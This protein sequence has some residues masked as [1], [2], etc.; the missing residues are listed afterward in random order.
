M[1]TPLIMLSI[2][3]MLGINATQGLVRKAA[4]VTNFVAYSLIFL[5]AYLLTTAIFG[6]GWWNFVVP[7]YFA[8]ISVVG[9]FI[10]PFFLKSH[11]NSQ[12]YRTSE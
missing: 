9:L 10:I 12:S 6:I 11:V 5:G 1:A 7:N 8:W 2:L 3:G 4:L